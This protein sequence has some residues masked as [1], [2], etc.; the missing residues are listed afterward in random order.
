[1]IEHEKNS[2]IIAKFLEE[3]DYIKKVTHPALPTHPQYEL[4]KQQ[5]KAAMGLIT[6]VLKDSRREAIVKFCES[7]KAFIIAVSWG[8]HES[9]VIPRCAGIKKELFDES[10]EVHRHIRLYIGLEDDDY[11]IKDLEQALSVS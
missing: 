4:A 5:M 1:M 9:L 6:I 11:L 7:L 10:N 2:I 8:G 3:Q